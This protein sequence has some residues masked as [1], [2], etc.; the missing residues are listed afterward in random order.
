MIQFKNL[1][2]SKPYSLLKTK[3]DLAFS[4]KQKNIDAFLVSSYS[5]EDKEVDAR[6]VN[7]KFISSKDFIF[8]SNYSS[9]KAKQFESHNQVTSVIYWNS[10]NVQIRIK[11]FIKKTNRKFNENYFQTR[12]PR[13]NALAISS[14]QS[15]IIES[16]NAVE[17]NYQNS[18]EN[19]NI[20]ECPDYWGG[21]SLQP[22]YFE[23]WEGHKTRL[24]KREAYKMVNGDWV[25][26]FLQP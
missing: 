25:C 8:F 11:G 6:Y 13:K 26:S 18:L 4:K 16:Y 17:I 20:K 7:L 22:Y 9:P 14:K 19:K 15:V 1:C 24:N 23:F 21:F 5:M 2:K 3:Y 12:D 10:I